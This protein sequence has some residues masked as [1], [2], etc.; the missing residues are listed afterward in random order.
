MVIGDITPPVITLLGDNPFFLEC[1]DG[2]NDPGATA[3]DDYDG[4]VTANIQVGGTVD[5]Q[6]LGDYIVTYSVSDAAGNSSSTSRT[7]TVQDTTP[8]DLACPSPP[9]GHGDSGRALLLAGPGRIH[10]DE[11]TGLVWSAG[12]NVDSWMTAAPLSTSS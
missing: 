8:P 10:T 7:V 2:F 12:R 6:V 4:D 5:S 1:P 3:E 9:T 11:L